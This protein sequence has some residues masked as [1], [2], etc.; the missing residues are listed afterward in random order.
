LPLNCA[1]LSAVSGIDT[2]VP[3]TSLTGLPR[4]SHDLSWCWL[5][6]WTVAALTRSINANG[7]R[8]RALQ[9]GPVFKLA[10]LP[11]RPALRLAPCATALRQL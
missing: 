3:S 5:I 7:S 2:V 9:Y 4:H 6:C 11:V 1:W 10:T 8:L